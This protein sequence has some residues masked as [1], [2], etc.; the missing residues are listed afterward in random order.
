MKGVTLAQKLYLWITFSKL[1]IC[2]CKGNN[3]PFEIK[4]VL[5][6]YRNK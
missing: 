4:L 2:F 6:Q 1:K 3:F 5:C